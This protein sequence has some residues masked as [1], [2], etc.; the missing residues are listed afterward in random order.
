[1][2]ELAFQEGDSKAIENVLKLEMEKPVKHFEKELLS[3]RTGKASTSMIEDIKVDCYG[4]LMK[5]RELATLS[6]PESRLLTIQPWDKSIIG[7]I[8]KAILA[9]DLGCSPINDGNIIRIQIP[10][11]SSDRREELVKQLNKK[12]EECKVS[13]RNIRKDVHNEIRD[14]EKKKI[15]SEDFAKKLSQIMQKITDSFIEKVDQLA[16]KKAHEVREI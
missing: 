13:I 9:S 4:Q 3:L 12:T 11:M 2:E 7:E 16:T 5:L 10:Q 14:A 6:A 8:E 1:M 15:I